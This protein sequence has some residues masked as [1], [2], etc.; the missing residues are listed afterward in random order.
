MTSGLYP[1]TTGKT[2]GF[3]DIKTLWINNGGNPTYANIMAAIAIA[4]SGGQTNVLNNTPGTGDYSVGLWQINYYNGLLADR[5]HE[6]GAPEALAQDPNA[7]AQAAIALMETSPKLTDWEGDA[8]WKAWNAAGSPVPWNPPASLTGGAAITGPQGSA[9]GSGSS[10]GS[11][12]AGSGSTTTT[13]ASSSSCAVNLPG[14]GPIGG[15]CLI[16]NSEIKALKGG[17]LL[18]AG[19]ITFIVGGLIL[20]AYGF[21]RTQAGREASQVARPVTRAASTAAQVTPEGR[22]AKVAQ[23]ATRATTARTAASAAKPATRS[24]VTQRPARQPSSTPRPLRAP[25]PDE[26]DRLYARTRGSGNANRAAYR[27]QIG[28]RPRDTSDLRR[29]TP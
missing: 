29:R 1:G 2:L 19:G 3:G 11:G 26:G 23:G 25:G 22:V 14:V 6:F 15:G 17:L 10:G 9:G 7:Q 4:E 13:T 27:R 8:A 21:Q 16:T 5:T 20:V 24:S 28:Q 18:A 12:S